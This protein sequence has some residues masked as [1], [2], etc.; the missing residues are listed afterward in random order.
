MILCCAMVFRLR[1]I[2]SGRVADTALELP[3]QQIAQP[4]LQKGHHAWNRQILG[5]KKSPYLCG[6]NQ[7]GCRNWS[8]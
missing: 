4:A 7:K 1:D 6:Q 2:F 8:S 3:G 5:D